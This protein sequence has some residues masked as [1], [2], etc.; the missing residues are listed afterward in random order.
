M[1]GGSWQSNRHL[2]SGSR[3]VTLYG[4]AAARAPRRDAVW[5]LRAAWELFVAM[6]AEG[7]AARTARAYDVVGSASPSEEMP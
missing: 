2:T 4:M 7:F 1:H 6:G 5:Q 3:P